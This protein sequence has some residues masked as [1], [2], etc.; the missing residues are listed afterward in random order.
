MAQIIILV[1]DIK[2]LFPLGLSSYAMLELISSYSFSLLDWI[3]YDTFKFAAVIAPVIWYIYLFTKTITS[4]KAR[5]E[6]E[7]LKKDILK[8]Q[9]E[10]EVRKKIIEEAELKNVEFQNRLLQKRIDKEQNTDT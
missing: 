6:N 3:K 2:S 1:K 4:R 5:K 10:A 9:Q 8:R 7:E